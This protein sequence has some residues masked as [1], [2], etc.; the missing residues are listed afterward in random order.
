MLNVSCNK[1][2]EIPCYFK[3]DDSKM[4]ILAVLSV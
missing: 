2:N 3:I 1:F 4:T